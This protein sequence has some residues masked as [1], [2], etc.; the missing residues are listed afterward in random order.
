MVNTALKFLT[1]LSLKILNGKLD[2]LFIPC[3]E[4]FSEDSTF[5]H[6]NED[7][8]LELIEQLSSDEM[9]TYACFLLATRDFS[10]HRGWMEM[11]LRPTEK[12]PKW[13]EK[14]YILL[15]HFYFAVLPDQGDKSEKLLKRLQDLTTALQYSILACRN[16]KDCEGTALMIAKTYIL[17]NEENIGQYRESRTERKI[18]LDW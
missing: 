17:T 5:F 7:K 1:R 4:A 15:M 14:E 6:Q 9:K 13:H 11:A 8:M 3:L 12:P 16:G 10:N 18:K 2:S